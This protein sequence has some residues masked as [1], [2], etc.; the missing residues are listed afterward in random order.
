MTVS[1]F[2]G[3]AVGGAIEDGG[4]VVPA[5]KRALPALQKTESVPDV[6]LHSE[7]LMSTGCLECM[8]SLQ[9]SPDQLSIP[10]PE[11]ALRQC[12]AN[13]YCRTCCFEQRR[14]E[15]DVFST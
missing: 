10:Y 6:V 12:L 8:P 2:H 13:T 14:H 15:R 3:A 9:Q 5:F 1:S 11:A 7:V 4:G